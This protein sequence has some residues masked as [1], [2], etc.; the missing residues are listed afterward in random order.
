MPCDLID[1]K[2]I[3]LLLLFV[4]FELLVKVDIKRSSSFYGTSGDV[5][6]LVSVL[7]KG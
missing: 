7:G 6:S 2:V 4:G 3:F 1:L 5:K